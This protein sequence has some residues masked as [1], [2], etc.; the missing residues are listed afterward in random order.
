MHRCDPLRRKTLPGRR[1]R[2]PIPH[3]AG[4]RFLVQMLKLASTA[5]REM[6]TGRR[7]MMRS[8]GQG[9]IPQQQIARCGER[10]VPPACR[11]PVALCRDPQDAFA[12]DLVRTH[13]HR[14]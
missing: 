7:D 6:T 14:A 5:L 10:H 3:E 11:H 9:P 12:L 8:G 2:D 13:R 4:E 1:M